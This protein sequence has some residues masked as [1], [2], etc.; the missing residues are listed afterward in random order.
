VG[1]IRLSYAKVSGRFVLNGAHLDGR[2]GPALAAD[3]LTV[4]ADV[5]CDEKF[6]A[7]GEVQLRGTNIGG[8]LS[9]S[10]AHLDGGAGGAALAAD[11]LTVAAELFFDHQF[12]ADGE[13]RLRGAHINGQ[14]V[15]RGAQLDGGGGGAALA[16][17]GLTVAAD[18]ICDEQF[19]ADGVVSLVNA[20]IGRRLVLSGAHLDGKDRPALAADGLTVATDMVCDEQFHADGE[21][22][23]RGANIGGQ[24]VFHDAHL[25]GRNE[26]ALA[27]D[28][29]TVIA[30]MYLDGQFLAKGEVRLGNAKV[31]ALFD[32]KDAWP[33]RLV[34]EGFTYDSLTAMKPEPEQ[35]RLDWLK[36]SDY[37]HGQPYEQLAANYR[38]LGNDAQARRVLLAKQRR[39]RRERPWRERGWDLLQDAMAGYGY[40]PG[41]AFGLLAG[42]FVLG[43]LVFQAHHPA[44]V[45]PSAH[46]EFN[47]ALFTF[48]VLIP[49]PAL[50]QASDWDPR[51]VALAVAVALHILGWLLA[52]TVI[53][54]I[55]RT[56]ARN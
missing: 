37:Y 20:K 9:F 10:G 33:Q 43:W 22:Q 26:A 15:F 12:R 35:A 31:G 42:A 5:V 34:L 3:G 55:T 45:D 11:G 56:F 50:G 36:R 48:D 47:A 38:R 39:R 32:E 13:I 30:E 44:P 51:G 7:N 18:M 19:H 25:D 6:R 28:G 27:A 41:R 46:R 49:V 24:L 2:G 23:L 4:T 54:A 52:I 29:L 14:L 17:D 53:A 21:V 16:A 1:P 40:V 8:Q